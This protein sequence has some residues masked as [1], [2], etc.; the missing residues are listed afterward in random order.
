MNGFKYL[1]EEF[2]LHVASVVAMGKY[3]KPTGSR[4]T[5]SGWDP[6][7]SDYDFVVLDQD[8]ELSRFLCSNIDW[9]EGGSGNGTEFCSFKFKD[10]LNFILVDNKDIFNKYVAAT[11]A[12]KALDCKTKK[13]RIAVFDGIFVRTPEVL[14]F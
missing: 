4:V 7:Q 13:E 6:K 5:K 10:K 1:P 3:I 9:V 11:E 8:K 2:A 14:P 12:I